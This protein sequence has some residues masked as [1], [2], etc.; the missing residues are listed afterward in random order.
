MGTPGDI[1]RVRCLHNMS[2]RTAYLKLF[3]IWRRQA[4]MQEPMLAA[5]EACK[6]GQTF[7]CAQSP[8]QPCKLFDLSF[9]ITIA[10]CSA[11]L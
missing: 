4:T 2:K 3:F 6:F 9:H 7:S 11:R 5:A 10:V 8:G 1:R